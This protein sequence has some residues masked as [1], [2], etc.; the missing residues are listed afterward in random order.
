M[1]AVGKEVF[2]LLMMASYDWEHPSLRV[3]WEKPATA[4]FLKRSQRIKGAFERIGVSREVEVTFFE[5][6]IQQKIKI[7]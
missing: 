1:D 4:P 5:G 6:S 7:I 2:C 3:G